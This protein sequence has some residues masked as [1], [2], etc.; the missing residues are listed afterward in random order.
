M[1][2]ELVY[3]PLES[4]RFDP[5]NPRLPPEVGRDQGSM[6]RFLVDEIGVEDLLASIAA[7]GFIDGDPMIGRESEE[8][9][10]I[11]LE[12]N[13]RLAAI[14]LLAQTPVPTPAANGEIHEQVRPAPPAPQDFAAFIQQVPLEINWPAQ[15]LAA[16]LG[17]KHVTAAREWSP[18]AKARYVLSLA[19]GDLSNPTLRRFA[20]ELGTNMPTLKRWLVAL[21]VLFQAEAWNQYDPELAGTRRFFGT[22]YTIL[23]SAEVQRFLGIVSD[24]LPERPVPDDH[25]HQLGLLVNWV[26]GS[27]EEPPIVNS[28]SQKK[29]EKIL[30]SP[31]AVDHLEEYRDLNAALYQTDYGPE[32]VAA[33]L[34]RAA[35]IVESATEQLPEVKDSPGVQEALDELVDAVAAAEN[36]ME[37]AAEEP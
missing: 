26:V 7:V 5:E 36:A 13:R 35:R 17:Y 25:E 29:L 28:R 8:G 1:P 31:A 27:V 30:S 19:N 23:G 22:F 37:E 4:L 3:A 10:Y 34:L 9:T 33:N 15:G 16:Y 32:E 2:G 12:G 21:L 14:K 18:D 6:Y 20:S 11:V 24:P